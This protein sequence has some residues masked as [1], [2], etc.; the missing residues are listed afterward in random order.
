MGDTERPFSWPLKP[1]QSDMMLIRSHGWCLRVKDHE[2]GYLVPWISLR[3]FS[4]SKMVAP[5][6]TLYLT[7]LS[8]TQPLTL[9]QHELPCDYNVL[10]KHNVLYC[11]N[12]PAVTYQ[13]W[14][15]KG[16]G[17]EWGMRQLHKNAD[18]GDRVFRV[19]NGPTW[20]DGKGDN[21]SP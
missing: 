8:S 15:V 13:G 17:W 3:V 16:K 6:F 1:T 21:S 19:S 5:L 12:W 7:N 14:L 2:P 4:E 11:H 20:G 10:Y 9:S 18:G